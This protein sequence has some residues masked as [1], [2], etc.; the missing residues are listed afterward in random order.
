[1]HSNVP[2]DPTPSDDEH[3]H[4]LRRMA[5]EASDATWGDTPKG[6]VIVPGVLSGEVG[7]KGRIS[8]QMRSISRTERAQYGEVPPGA[9][10]PG[11]HL[12]LLVPMVVFALVVLALAVLLGWLL[13]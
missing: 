5:D 12:L 7:P 2:S 9:V 10:A 3:Q 8:A 13:S 1:M 6:R 11:G 4:D